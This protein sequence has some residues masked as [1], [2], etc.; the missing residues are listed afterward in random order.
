M[1]IEDCRRA[2]A[3]VEVVR[4][5]PDV[6]DAADVS[7][8]EPSRPAAWLE[9]G[10]EPEEPERFRGLLAAVVAAD[11]GRTVPFPMSY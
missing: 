11:T 6:A 8:V 7:G 2:P 5:G 1:R 9:S 3:D 10:P 4:E